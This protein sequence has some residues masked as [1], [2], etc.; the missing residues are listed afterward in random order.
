MSGPSGS[1]RGVRCATTSSSSP[2]AG[3]GMLTRPGP[4]AQNPPPTSRNYA[5]GGCWGWIS[6]TITSPTCVLDASG[7]P[8]GE[9]TTIDVDTA[10]LAA[11]RR[12][13]RLR[14]AI[15]ALLDHAESQQCRAIVIENLNFADARATGRETLGRGAR[16]K[17]LRRIISGISTRRFRDRLIVWRPGAVSR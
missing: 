4:P 16:G 14:A 8:V 17:R 2:I 3:A 11:S 13:G 1:Q 7:N 5:T 9:P 12:D 10:G 6:T 15:T